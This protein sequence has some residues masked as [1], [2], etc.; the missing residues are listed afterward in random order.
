[1]TEKTL[2]TE[3]LGV[4][5]KPRVRIRPKKS[6]DVGTQAGREAVIKSARRVIKEHHAVLTALKDR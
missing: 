3:L 2:L 4:Q 5:V 1:M 6:V